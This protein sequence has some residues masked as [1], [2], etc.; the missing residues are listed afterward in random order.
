MDRDT[1]GRRARRRC[2]VVAASASCPGWRPATSLPM[3]STVPAPALAV[4]HSAPSSDKFPPGTRRPCLPRRKATLAISCCSRNR[5]YCSSSSPRRA[6]SLHRI[7]SGRPFSLSRDIDPPLPLKRPDPFPPARAFHDTRSAFRTP[8]NARRPPFSRSISLSRSASVVA[9]SSP[10]SSSDNSPRISGR[11][12]SSSTN[13][14]HASP[15]KSDSIF[16]MTIFLVPRESNPSHAPVHCFPFRTSPGLDR[17][18]LRVHHRVDDRLVVCQFSTIVRRLI[19]TP[20]RPLSIVHR[21]QRLRDERQEPLHRER[22]LPVP[23]SDRQMQMIAH[24]A[25]RVERAAHTSAQ[26]APASTE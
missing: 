24:R 14:G 3:S 18:R 25:D 20:H 12:I 15:G 21:V 4:P 19:R 7:S 6:G 13:F 26:R 8:K 22:E 9:I 1:S 23:A 11:T 17:I 2:R 10:S 16:S 5:A